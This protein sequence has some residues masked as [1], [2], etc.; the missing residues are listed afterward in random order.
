MWIRKYNPADC[1][2]LTELFYNTVHWIHLHD[3]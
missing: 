3:V 2:R 1:E